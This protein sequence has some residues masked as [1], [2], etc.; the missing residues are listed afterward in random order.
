MT[1][2]NTDASVPGSDPD[3]LDPAGDLAADPGLNTTVRIARA[4]LKDADDDGG[5]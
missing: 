1:D 3:H 4:L 5:E 2:D